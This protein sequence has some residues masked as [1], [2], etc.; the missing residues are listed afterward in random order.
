MKNKITPQKSNY[1]STRQV[2]S[3]RIHHDK[4]ISID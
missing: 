3:D 4:I 2:S 1:N